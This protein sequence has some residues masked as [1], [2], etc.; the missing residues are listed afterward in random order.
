MSKR[1][2]YRRIYKSLKLPLPPV[3]HLVK[4]LD[5]KGHKGK[6]ISICAHGRDSQAMTRGKPSVFIM[7]RV[8]FIPH[9]APEKFLHSIIKNIVQTLYSLCR[10]AVPQFFT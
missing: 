3:F 6:L 8:G 7:Q 4:S 2:A 10:G 1:L 9:Y 5:R